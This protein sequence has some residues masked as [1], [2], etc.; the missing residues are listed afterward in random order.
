MFCRTTGTRCDG[1]RPGF[2]QR[3]ALGIAGS[4]ADQ[5]IDRGRQATGRDS[6]VTSQQQPGAALARY[7]L[8]GRA[9]GQRRRCDE[10]AQRQPP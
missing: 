2:R 7:L 3:I 8:D 10:Q 6:V 1:I 9:R 4:L 5:D